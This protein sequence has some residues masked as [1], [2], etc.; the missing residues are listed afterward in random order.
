MTALIPS[1]AEASIVVHVERLH[2]EGQTGETRTQ[3]AQGVHEIVGP[4]ARAFAGE[5]KDMLHAHLRQHGG[6]GQDRLVVEDQALDAIL[7]A[8]PAVGA[9]VAAHIRQVERC[10][11][12]HR[13][14]ESFDGALVAGL[15][16]LLQERRRGRGQQ[17]SE[18]IQRQAATSATERAAH[19]RRAL[20]RDAIGD[21]AKVVLA[22]QGLE[23]HGRYASCLCPRKAVSG[24]EARATSAACG[25][26][27]S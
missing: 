14:A 25:S 24:D 12:L 22:P 19:V 23:A 2:L 15:R 1:S 4:Y 13:S 18:I 8:E 11:E 5:Q 21:G 10:I 9:D 6:L 3:Q 27:A 16:H 7:R 17:G 26:P 20:A